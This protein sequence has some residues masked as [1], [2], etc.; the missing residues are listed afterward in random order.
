MKRIIIL[1]ALAA[2]DYID[3][4]QHRRRRYMRHDYLV[5]AGDTAP[6][7]IIKE[8]GGEHTTSPICGA[9]LLCFSSPPAGAAYA[10]RRCPLSRVRYGC[11]ERKRDWLVI[12]IDRDEPEK[13][14]LK[15]REDMKI[16]YPLAL[17]PGAEIFRPFCPEGGRCDP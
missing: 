12:G 7:F 13:T 2:R 15:F 10:G 11:P 17:D 8:A 6:D 1:F 9:R 3:C 14:V 5:R 4:L 16:T